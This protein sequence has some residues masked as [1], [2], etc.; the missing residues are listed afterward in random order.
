MSQPMFKVVGISELEGL[1]I[2]FIELPYILLGSGKYI[3]VEYDEKLGYYP[4]AG[5]N[6]FKTKASAESAILDR[7]SFLSDLAQYEDAE[8]LK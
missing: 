8:I 6:R 7:I 5:V 2:S 1:G 4:M 3:I